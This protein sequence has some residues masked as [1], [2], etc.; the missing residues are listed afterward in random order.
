MI[1]API[2]GKIGRF[3]GNQ[4]PKAAGHKQR[5]FGPDSHCGFQGRFPGICILLGILS[6][7]ISLL[8]LIVM[9]LTL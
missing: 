5:G 2:G 7:V 8:S 1:T 4:P 6:S 9:D 3:K